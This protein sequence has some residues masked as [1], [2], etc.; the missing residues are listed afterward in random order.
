MAEQQL[1][2]Q[3]QTCSLASLCKSL[4][5]IT[6]IVIFF[7]IARFGGVFSNETSR[8]ILSWLRRYLFM[9]WRRRFVIS[10][11]GAGMR[12]TSPLGREK[13]MARQRRRKHPVSLSLHP[14][15]GRVFALSSK[16]RS[17]LAS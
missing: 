10:K 16:R 2:Y 3:T 12:N 13:R 6:R 9:A 17:T 8:S 4:R 5:V 14:V 15:N 7:R 1:E 11:T